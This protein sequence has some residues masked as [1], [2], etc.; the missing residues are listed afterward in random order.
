MLYE[1]EV[2]DVFSE[3]EGAFSGDVCVVPGGDG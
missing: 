1:E 3:L 2:V